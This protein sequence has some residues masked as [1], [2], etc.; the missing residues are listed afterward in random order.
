MI[1]QQKG[2]K[3]IF[4]NFLDKS[5]DL[6]MDKSRSNFKERQQIFC[7]FYIFHRSPNIYESLF[8]PRP[9]S[10]GSVGAALGS[11][12]RGLIVGGTGRQAGREHS[13]RVGART[14][15]CVVCRKDLQTL[16]VE[17]S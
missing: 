15:L 2:L 6:N 13:V 14:S 16:E 17:A 4:I 5:S 9:D 3:D 7:A 10:S 1:Y 11:S 12:S 8:V